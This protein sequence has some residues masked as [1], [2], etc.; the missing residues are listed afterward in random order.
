MVATVALLTKVAG[1]VGEQALQFLP[2][3]FAALV[4][5]ELMIRYGLLVKLEPLGAPLTRLSRLP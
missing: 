3:T 4:A 2:F 5:T 1:M